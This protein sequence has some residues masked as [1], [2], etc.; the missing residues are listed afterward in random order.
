MKQAM[1]PESRPGSIKLDDEIVR[2]SSFPSMSDFGAKENSPEKNPPKRG[3]VIKSDVVITKR[4]Q[5]F[6][7]D[8]NAGPAGNMFSSQFTLEPRLPADQTGEN[9]ER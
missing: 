4:F 8:F 7:D 5:I 9:D 2:D 6:P 1:Q 3:P